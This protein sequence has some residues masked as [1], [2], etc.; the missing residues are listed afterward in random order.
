MSI[1]SLAKKLAHHAFL[2][3]FCLAVGI[4]LIKAVVLGQ[5]MMQRF[6]GLGNDDIMRMSMVRDLI[7]GQSW[8]DQTQYRIVPPQGVPIHWSRF[9]DAGIAAVIVPLSWFMPMP[10]AEMVGVV[11]WPTLILILTIAVVGF[12]TRRVFGDAEAVFALTCLVFWPLTADLH[13]RPGNIDHHNVQFL[14][15]SIVLLSLVW[16]GNLVRA[17]LVAG[18]AA[19]FSLAVGLEN[20]VFIVLSG[21]VFLVRAC[22]SRGAYIAQLHA[23]CI[24]L[25]AAASVLWI[26]QAPDDFRFAR[27][28]DQL[29][30][31]VLTLI[32]IA[33]VA[34]LVP[35]QVLRPA[36]GGWVF[37]GGASALTLGGL[38]FAWPLTA[39]CLAGPYAALTPEISQFIGEKINEARPGLIFFQQRPTAALLFP[40]PI[41]ATVLLGFN[42]LATQ[43]RTK[44]LPQ[45]TVL[46]VRIYLM[47]CLVGLALV[48][49]QMRTI[50]LAA[51]PVPMLAGVIL[52]VGMRD[53]L[54]TRTAGDASKLLLSVLFMTQPTILVYALGPYLPPST[55]SLSGFECRTYD[56]IDSLNDVPPATILSHASF[57][58]VT[59]WV[60]HHDVLAALYHRSE[61]AMSNAILPWQ[62]SAEEV[63]AVVRA[64]GA[65]LLML[66]KGQQLESEVLNSLSEGVTL[67]WLRAIPVDREEL[68][69]YEVLPE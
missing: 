31:P 16:R 13:A 47:F 58:P 34:S 40:L 51:T 25:V 33:S 62:A 15:M 9:I 60:T 37:L 46:A 24:A 5:D 6:A 39:T 54:R 30:V 61:A 10:Q 2:L 3:A 20:L 12:G 56:I 4:S 18:M 52:A 26:G 1:Q 64:T 53:Y 28:C 14:M 22:F 35:F 11:I 38:A 19:A 7:A 57:G 48:A 50:N 43:R 68:L 27:I 17:G 45:E 23:F 65:E 63:E 49:Y 67:P 36:A 8:F 59:I 32:L 44:V 41:I 21:V 42:L 69:L 66:C 55:A 29:G